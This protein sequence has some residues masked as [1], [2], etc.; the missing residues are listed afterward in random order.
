MLFRFVHP[1]NADGSIVVIDAGIFKYS[2]LFKSL[3]A[4]LPI[5]SIVFGSVML[6][7]SFGAYVNAFSPISLTV[8]VPYVPYVE[9]TITCV[10]KPEYSFTM[11]EDIS[12]PLFDISFI[13]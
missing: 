9:G 13:A 10:S 4:S 3:N 5:F 6:K 1:K 11:P 8:P 12:T 2:S 7:I